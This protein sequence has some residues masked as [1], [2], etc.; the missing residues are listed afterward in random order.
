M[1]TVSVF[2]KRKVRLTS[3]LSSKKSTFLTKAESFFF[4]L[5]YKQNSQFRVLG[6][7]S[8]KKR[9]M[10]YL[11][12]ILTLFRSKHEA[13]R[14]VSDHFD[15]S[16]SEKEGHRQQRHAVRR[17]TPQTPPGLSAPSAE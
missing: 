11:Q 6:L 14:K 13:G 7:Y 2:K 5:L 9:G 10:E 3:C 17:E 1:D 16:V 12:K 8:D 15:D 4:F